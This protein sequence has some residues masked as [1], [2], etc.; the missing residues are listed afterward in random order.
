MTETVSPAGL[1]S[2][3]LSSDERDLGT[4]F[5]FYF[6]APIVHLPCPVNV[7]L[8]ET[9]VLL[10]MGPSSLFHAQWFLRLLVHL[11]LEGGGGGMRNLTRRSWQ[12]A[13]WTL[14][15]RLECIQRS[16]ISRFCLPYFFVETQ[17]YKWDFIRPVAREVTWPPSSASTTAAGAHFHEP[18]VLPCNSGRFR[19]D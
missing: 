2:A 12:L 4:V 6:V 11:S 1:L 16:I 19:P 5:C 17:F 7:L 18:F 14:F 13:C 10:L 9:F 8:F 3:R 15:D